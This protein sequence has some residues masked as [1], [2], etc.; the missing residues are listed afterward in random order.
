MI[1]RIMVPLDGSK[2]SEQV[3]PMAQRLAEATG[4]EVVLTNAIAGTKGFTGERARDMAQAERDAAKSYLAAVRAMLSAK[5]LSVEA[6]VE[7]GRPHIAISS[8][9]DREKI[10]LV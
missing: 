8:L 9:C 5:G 10:D 6:A 7:E 3:L 4:A 2:T 1:K